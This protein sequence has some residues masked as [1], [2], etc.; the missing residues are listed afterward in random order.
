MKENIKKHW[1]T[2][3][4]G[5]MPILVILLGFFGLDTEQSNTIADMIKGI[6]LDYDGGMSAM[7]IVAAILTL[8]SYIVNIFARDPKKKKEE[9][10]S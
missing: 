2:T 1:I 3:V 6:L 8:A 10:S 7:G 5:L 4:I 9:V